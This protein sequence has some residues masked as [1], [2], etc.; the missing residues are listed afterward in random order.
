MKIIKFVFIE[1]SH[2]FKKE[3]H[4]VQDLFKEEAIKAIKEQSY[5]VSC[6]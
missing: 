4:N 2:R 6:R 3:V 1:D 5:G